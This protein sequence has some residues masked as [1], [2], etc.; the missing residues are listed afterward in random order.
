M[1]SFNEIH[2]LGNLGKDPVA[3][4][5]KSGATICNFSIATK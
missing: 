2:L 3:V 5:T 4:A 1:A